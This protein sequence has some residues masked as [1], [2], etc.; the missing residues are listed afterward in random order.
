MKEIAQRLN[1]MSIDNV[2]K[3]AVQWF[4]LQSKHFF[5]EGKY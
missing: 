3:A 5:A 2:L 4:M 1:I